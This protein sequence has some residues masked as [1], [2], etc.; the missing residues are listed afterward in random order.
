M[1][2]Q[3]ISDKPT[4]YTEWLNNL[5]IKRKGDNRLYGSLDPQYWHTN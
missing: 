5:R 1:E 3:G 2:K 4:G